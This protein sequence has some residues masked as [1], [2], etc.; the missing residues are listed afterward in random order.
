[1]PLMDDLQ[2]G[3]YTRGKLE[4]EA[5]NA[6]AA[7]ETLGVLGKNPLAKEAVARIYRTLGLPYEEVVDAY[8][9]A[10][11]CGARNLIPP[12][13][14]YLDHYNPSDSRLASYVE[15]VHAGVESQDI[16]IISGLFIDQLL[17]GQYEGAAQVASLAI[18]L[19]DPASMSELAE[20]LIFPSGKEE[21][22]YHLN[23][24]DKF[25][26]Q[27]WPV[28]ISVIIPDSQLLNAEGELET[29][30]LKQREAV[31]AE[32]DARKAYRDF[33]KSLFDQGEQT[34]YFGAGRLRALFEM[35]DSDNWTAQ[36]VNVF[37]H[38]PENSKAFW[39][40]PDLIL[41]Y[42]FMYVAQ[43]LDAEVEWI[44]SGISKFGLEDVFEQ[45]IERALRSDIRRVTEETRRMGHMRPT[46]FPE[47]RQLSI[48]EG[49]IEAA[50]GSTISR[51]SIESNKYCKIFDEGRMVDLAAILK[52]DLK[53]A[54]MGSE[55]Q[56]AELSIFF[57]LS[58]Y[59]AED[60]FYD[61]IRESFSAISDYSK[62]APAPFVNQLA[63]RFVR[64][65]QKNF[66]EFNSRQTY[67]PE[68]LLEMEN[69]SPSLKN[70]ITELLALKFEL[71]RLDDLFEGMWDYLTDGNPDYWQIFQEAL[72]NEIER[73]FTRDG[74]NFIN[75][76][77]T[78]GL[79]HNA[80]ESLN[81]TLEPQL[82]SLLVCAKYISE[83]D[84]HFICG[85][86]ESDSDLDEPLFSTN[87]LN[88]LNQLKAC[89][90]CG[91]REELIKNHPNA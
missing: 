60:G 58:N 55:S 28:P 7:I 12:L 84:P 77:W 41:F 53:L 75:D 17:T 76:Y 2:L 56:V 70:S 67:L 13:C 9:D 48:Y 57:A 18:Q 68:A 10:I 79:F 32:M 22:I 74:W 37:A 27:P 15:Q 44:R 8:I 59:Y 25:N 40:D 88:E 91:P 4:F 24:R 20:I 1:M 30:P 5:G 26:P 72:A 69:L 11:E 43:N 85:L 54:A 45:T 16:Q 14:S 35:S 21:L 52:E 65:A 82:P 34:P 46:I 33:V 38:S 78:D 64:I 90:E 47:G 51:E 66:D 80:V 63:E 31:K 6:E 89:D 61:F 86:I 19:R 73:G 62:D 71:E 3:L 49:F 36:M 23:D 29:D 81:E 50:E 87:V 83:W 39:S 42:T